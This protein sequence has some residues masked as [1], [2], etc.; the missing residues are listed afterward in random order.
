VLPGLCAAALALANA[1]AGGSCRGNLSPSEMR[2]ERSALNVARGR[3]SARGPVNYRYRFQYLCFCAGSLLTAVEIQVRAGRVVAV[4]EPATGRPA[5]AAPGRPSP[6]VEDLFAVVQSSLDRGV[7]WIDVQ[8]DPVLGYPAVIR[9][10]P[11]TR[12]ADEEQSYFAGSL[13]PMD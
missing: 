6:T 7:D 5:P 11:D 2:G 10:D 3:W 12:A 1:I 8:Y 13:T 9:I 4:L